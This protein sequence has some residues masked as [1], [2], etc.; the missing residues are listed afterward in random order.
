MDAI[1]AIER[2]HGQVRSEM[3]VALARELPMPGLVLVNGRLGRLGDGI[4]RFAFSLP[5]EHRRNPRFQKLVRDLRR[6]HED[7]IHFFSLHGRAADEDPDA[8]RMVVGP[9]DA[10]TELLFGKFP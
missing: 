1:E 9:L 7:L 8:P 5:G 10:L 4:Q 6:T 3:R 2:A